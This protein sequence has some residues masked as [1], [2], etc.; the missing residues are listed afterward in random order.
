M[1]YLEVKIQFK[2]GV[3]KMYKCSDIPSIG[4]TWT[5]IYPL[6]DPLK[7]VLMA[8]EGIEKIEY[9]YKYDKTRKDSS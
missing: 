6:D 1:I 5:T 3:E 2:D 4:D 9:T 8:S 7:R